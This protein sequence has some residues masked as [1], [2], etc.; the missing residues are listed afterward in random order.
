MCALYG[1]KKTKPPKPHTKYPHVLCFFCCRDD[2]SF[3]LN[4]VH[5]E[6][7]KILKQTGDLVAKDYVM[8]TD[9]CPFSVRQLANAVN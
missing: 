1:K 2:A 8:V 6:T 5:K 4:I 7:V 9:K 3:F